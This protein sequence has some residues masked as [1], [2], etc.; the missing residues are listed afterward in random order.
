MTTV[1]AANQL[2]PDV[3]PGVS[4]G[5]WHDPKRYLWTIGTVIPLI[6]LVGW[7]LAEATGLTLF[8]FFGPIF[9]FGI[10]PVLDLVI[11]GDRMNPPDDAV[12]RLEADRYYRWITYLFI[13]FEFAVVGWATWVWST[14]HI[15]WVGNLGLA[16]TI[17]VVSGIAINT[18]HELGHKSLA[19]ETWLSRIAL[20]PTL[21]GH[22]YVEHNRGHHV[23]VATFEDPASS[24]LGESFYRFW[25]RTVSGSLKSAWR[26]EKTRL[27]R[28][29]RRTLSVHNQI[30]GA[31]A[32]S[33]VLFAGLTALG[34]WPV[35]G[36]LAIQA[37]LGFTLLEIVNYLEHYGLLR[38]KRADGRSTRTTP[39][40]SWNSNNTP[41]NLVLYHLQRHSDHHAHASRRYQALRH[42]DE[43]PQLPTGYGGMILVAVVPPV[44]RRM[45]DH[46]VAQHYDGD[47]LQA[48][49][50]PKLRAKLE[51]D[52]AA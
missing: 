47:L 50:T 6:P 31:W 3:L 25:P 9:L 33:V 7:G 10:L 11:G 38:E 21:Y 16:L 30:F 39:R 20:A 37:F 24:R 22:F 29:G 45:M 23:N 48:N 15:G 41:S 5:T 13:P 42:F 51:A 2:V 35:L 26:L 36:W 17:G 14:Q 19:V 34:G 12:A 52:R 4:G 18:A 49:L 8:W 43:S 40:H 28:Q 46:R 44:W 1:S 32:M 27:E